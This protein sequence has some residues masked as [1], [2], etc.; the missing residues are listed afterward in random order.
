MSGQKIPQFF[1]FSNRHTA[2]APPMIVVLGSFWLH[3]LGFAASGLPLGGS[4][5]CLRYVSP[6]W[7]LNNMYICH[8]WLE[9]LLLLL[10]LLLL[11]LARSWA[12]ETLHLNISI[13][14]LASERPHRY[15]N[16]TFL[17]FCHCSVSTLEWPRMCSVTTRILHTTQYTMGTKQTT[18]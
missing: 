16:G 8:K 17:Q 5:I 9:L 2:T 1:I 18:H 7:D 6:N 14:Q 12:V 4:L 13:H 15:S 11:V 3:P 10:L